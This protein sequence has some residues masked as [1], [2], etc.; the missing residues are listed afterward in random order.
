MSLADSLTP[1][2][3]EE[4]KPGLFIQ[5]YQGGYR[6]IKP[7]AWNG[8]IRWRE[9]IRT[10]FC[11]RTIFTIAL[12]LF[13]AWSYYSNTKSCEEFQ[14]NPCPY[15]GDLTDYCFGITQDINK[16]IPFII[17]N[18]KEMDSNPLSGDP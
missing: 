10:I 2:N 7:L 12:I 8:E 9:Q 4:I 1:K 3:T 5:S 16:N 13:L 17:E 14:A 18:G 15:L 6:Q 11:F